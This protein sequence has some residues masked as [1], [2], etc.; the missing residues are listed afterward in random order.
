MKLTHGIHLAYC[1][2]IHRGEDWPETLGTLEKFTL[3][4]KRQVA[5]DRPYAIGLRLSDKA[6]RELAQPNTLKAFRNWL[7]THHCYVYTING[8]PFGRFHGGRVKEQVAQPDWSYRERLD[9]TIRLFDILAELMVDEPRELDGSVSTVPLSFKEFRLTERQYSAAREN[10]WLCVEHLEQLSRRYGRRF[11]LGLEPEPLGFVENTAESVMLFEQLRADRP[12]DMRLAEHL[13]INY[14]ACHLAIEYEQPQDA[15]ARFRKAGI[16]ISKIHLSNALSVRPTV[17]A[18]EALKAFLDEVYF[19]QVIERRS[20]GELIRYR[21]LDEALVTSTDDGPQ[22]DRE[23]RIHFHIPLNATPRDVFGTTASHLTGVLDEVQR[24]PGMCSHFEM[25]TYT[26]EVMPAD[27][28]QRTVVQ[29]LAAEYGWTL[30][31][32]A[33]RG[34]R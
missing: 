25:E 13:G 21:D 33:K 20:D 12:G 1:T 3:A 18:R 16:R 27:L 4:V 32:F 7:K 5:P 15:F 6:S 28:K 30:E 2:N 9:Y 11:H 26:W 31:E 24:H 29:Q 10:L 14:D 19:H 34:I 23:W 17:A 22:L 8:F